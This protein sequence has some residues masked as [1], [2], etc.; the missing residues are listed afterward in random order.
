[1]EHSHGKLRECSCGMKEELEDKKA[2][3]PQPCLFTGNRL[4]PDVDVPSEA[5]ADL[6]KFDKQSAN[7]QVSKTQTYQSAKL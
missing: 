4:I 6:C 7:D 2:L 5:I 1:M 3:E